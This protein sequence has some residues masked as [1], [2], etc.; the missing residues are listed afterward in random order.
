MRPCAYELQRLRPWP[1]AEAA[2]IW[3]TIRPAQ[4]ARRRRLGRMRECQL[5]EVLKQDAAVERLVL[6][7]P[8]RAALVPVFERLFQ[9][10]LHRVDKLPVRAFDHHL[11]PAEIGSGEELETFGH[12]IELQTVILPDAQYAG[13]RWICTRCPGI[14]PGKIGSLVSVMRMKRY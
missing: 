13:R 9:V 12:A 8:T 10:K 6:V 14:D 5:Q 1:V 11:V 4:A 3:I 7:F 2:V